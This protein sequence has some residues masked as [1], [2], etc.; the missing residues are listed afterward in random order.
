MTI[1]TINIGNVV[2]DGL[3]DDLRTA[4]QKVNANFTELQS[5][6]TV[7]ASNLGTTGERIFKEKIGNDLKFKTL[8]AGNK[9]LLESLT[10]TIRVT[11]NVADAFNSI[12]TNLGA[13]TANNATGANNLTLQGA[14]GAKN[15]TVS[16]SGSVISID[17][18][19]DLN[20]ILLTY[21]FGL[22]NDADNAVQLAL[23]ATNFDF[24]TFPNPGRIDLDLGT[25]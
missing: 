9:V 11:A 22:I 15:I 13:V 25:I 1:Q 21:D 12:T 20:K 14:Q 3:G 10:D 16:A 18:V 17:T 23:S 6:L 19:L 2:N 8:T 5:T 24:G 7:T 4:F